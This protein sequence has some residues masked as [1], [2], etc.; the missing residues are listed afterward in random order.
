M[1][2]QARD[3]LDLRRR[4]AY[5]L[6]ALET[7]LQ[8]GPDDPPSSFEGKHPMAARMLEK[9]RGSIPVLNKH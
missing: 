7:D 9:R 8:A 4:W 6:E 1:A 2:L 3:Q 5:L